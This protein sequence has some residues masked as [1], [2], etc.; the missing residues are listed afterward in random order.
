MGES[1]QD[2]NICS[3]LRS[4]ECGEEYHFHPRQ[5]Q[6]QIPKST[7]FLLASSTFVSLFLFIGTVFYTSTYHHS[8][9]ALENCHNLT[10]ATP[11][12]PTTMKKKPAD[13]ILFH[14]DA[15]INR[16]IMYNVS[17][18][19][20]FQLHRFVNQSISCPKNMTKLFHH[21]G[22]YYLI[23]HNPYVYICCSP[24]YQ[25]LSLNMFSLNVKKLQT[26]E[27]LTVLEKTF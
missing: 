11:V 21:V 1:Q 5:Q 17:M 8:E 3:I 16:T 14:F 6:Q 26:L 12:I 20:R 4:C 13:L 2:H 22:C 15:K 18:G 7:R 19:E 10:I 23:V 25:F 9:S 27:F 24:R